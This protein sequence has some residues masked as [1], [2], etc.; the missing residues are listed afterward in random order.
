[1]FIYIVLVDNHMQR[2][3]FSLQLGV[4]AMYRMKKI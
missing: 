1:M 3:F 2:M 4:I